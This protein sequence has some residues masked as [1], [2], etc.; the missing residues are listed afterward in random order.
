MH[1][2][3]LQAFWYILCKIYKCVTE[4][5]INIHL[6]DIKRQL[7]IPVVFL[8]KIYQIAVIGVCV[9]SLHISPTG[10]SPTIVSDA[11]PDNRVGI[12]VLAFQVTQQAA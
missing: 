3:T 10:Q 11:T 1:S 9:T 12:F 6:I 4:I 2:T 5:I 7:Y 8:L